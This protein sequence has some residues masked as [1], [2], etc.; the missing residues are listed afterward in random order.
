MA[1]SS[2]RQSGRLVIALPSRTVDARPSSPP[3]NTDCVY[4]SEVRTPYRWVS[5]SSA[6]HHVPQH[7]PQVR[8][9]VEVVIVGEHQLRPRLYATTSRA[10]ES[11]VTTSVEVGLASYPF[12]ERRL[13]PQG[14]RLHG[15]HSLRLGSVRLENLSFVQKV[16]TQSVACRCL[17]ARRCR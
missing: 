7:E 5:H 14:Y 6:L 16:S 15:V 11:T 1:R 10:S 3:K 4:L 17:S 8:G 2:I 13:Q 9:A 12:S